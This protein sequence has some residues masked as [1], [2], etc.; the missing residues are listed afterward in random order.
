[1]GS[2]TAAPKRGYFLEETI[3]Q[4]NFVALPDARWIGG[5]AVAYR[6]GAVGRLGH[7]EAGQQGGCGGIV[8]SGGDELGDAYLLRS[9]IDGPRFTALATVRLPPQDVHVRLYT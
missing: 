3:R 9:Q 6:C 2:Q 1:M 4:P 5:L 7:V 8:V